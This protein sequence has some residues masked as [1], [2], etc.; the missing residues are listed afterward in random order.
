M[1]KLN[2]SILIS[3]AKSKLYDLEFSTST[4]ERSYGYIWQRL[5]TDIGDVEGLNI[6]HLQKH[7]ISY[8]GH[9]LFDQNIFLSANEIHVKFCFVELLYFME[10][11]NF[12]NLPT[13]KRQKTL[14]HYSDEVL[15]QYLCFQTSLGLKLI[16]ITKKKEAITRFLCSYPMEALSDKHILNYV[17]SFV[18]KNK[19]ASRLEINKVKHFLK[20]AYDNTYIN[21]DYTYLFPKHTISS[22][23]SISAP[24]N[25]D[26]INSVITAVKNLNSK[27]NK[28]NYAIIL[29]LATYGLRANDIIRL[30]LDD[31]D[32]DTNHVSI[33][34]SKTN[35]FLK[36]PLLPEI[37]NAII[38][39]LLH[40]RPSSTVR[41]VFLDIHGNPIQSSKNISC[42]V[43]SSFQNAGIDIRNKH[44]G[45]HSLRSS[46]ATRMLAN[47]TSIFTISKV[48][49]HASIDTTK[50]Y[51]KV[52]ITHLALCHLEVPSYD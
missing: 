8:Y 18:G 6:K 46:V 47:N 39:Y 21:M 4:V 42:L 12:H 22:K 13:H 43:N 26:E 31:I 16:T 25:E 49:G 37:G 33:V 38:D 50:I 9:D 10:H 24:Y 19:Y 29:L 52:D 17:G 1:N 45:A 36:F 48:L 30:T 14:T 44:H 34:T 2:L 28:R 20:Y 7:F 5:L 3:Q 15:K 51:T 35:V 27:T 32:W 41:N 23:N 11:Q 40:E